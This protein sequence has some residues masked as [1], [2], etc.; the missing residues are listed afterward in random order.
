MHSKCFQASAR[1][2]VLIGSQEICRCKLFP[3][4]ILHAG[5]GSTRFGD[6]GGN[7]NS[8]ITPLLRRGVEFI[9]SGMASTTNPNTNATHFAKSKPYVPKVYRLNSIGAAPSPRRQGPTPKDSMLLIGIG[10]RV[11]RVTVR[12]S[13]TVAKQW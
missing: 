12:Y 5:L 2:F 4:S 11:A 9:I 6:G 8:A 7:D 3:L 1:L 10:D 13:L